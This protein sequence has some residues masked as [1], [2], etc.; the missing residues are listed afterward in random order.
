M[1]RQYANTGKSAGNCLHHLYICGVPLRIVEDV[2]FGSAPG[3]ITYRGQPFANVTWNENEK[4][5]FTF[6]GEYS[7]Y[8][9][10][11]QKNPVK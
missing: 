3:V 7:A 1:Y 6:L 2:M 9:E 10:L 4:P 5:F 8:N 11:D